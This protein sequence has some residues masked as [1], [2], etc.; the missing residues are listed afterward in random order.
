MTLKEQALEAAVQAAQPL[1][2]IRYFNKKY[3]LTSPKDQKMEHTAGYINLRDVA[4]L[5]RKGCKIQVKN[6][7]DQSDCTKKTLQTLVFRSQLD[8]LDQL[9]VAE[10]HENLRQTNANALQTL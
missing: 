5:V 2:I 7:R 9:S 10:L 6:H 8:R 4:F 1:T 3:Y